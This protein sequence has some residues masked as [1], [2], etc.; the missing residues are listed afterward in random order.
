MVKKPLAGR[1]DPDGLVAA[2]W[3]MQAVRGGVPL[4]VARMRDG[5]LFRSDECGSLKDLAAE[6]AADAA[7]VYKHAMR[8]SGASADI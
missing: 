2:R 5:T 7:Y 3:N 4:R 8:K 6:L 1:S